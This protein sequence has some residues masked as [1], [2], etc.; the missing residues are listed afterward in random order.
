[1]VRF[2]LLFL[3]YFC[4]VGIETLLASEIMLLEYLP[5]SSFIK[6]NLHS[7]S[8]KVTGQYLIAPPP[9]LSASAPTPN[10]LNLRTYLPRKYQT[11][12]VNFCSDIN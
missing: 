4:W 11:I 2:S 10:L 5:T 8:I 7:L 3:I 12:L 1:M 9:S 6:P